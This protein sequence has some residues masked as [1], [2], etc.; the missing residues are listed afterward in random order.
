MRFCSILADVIA[1][2][3]AEVAW[4]ITR[5]WLPVIL[6][7]IAAVVVTAVIVHRRRK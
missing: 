6:L 3:P 1:L 5:P 4:E 2:T 7:V